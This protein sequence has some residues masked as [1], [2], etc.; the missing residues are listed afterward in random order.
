MP[1]RV[2][3]VDDSKISRKMIIK[4][5]PKD[6]DIEISEACNGKEALD[7][8]HAG[9]AEVMFLDLTM[10]V[11]DGYE[12]LEILKKEGLNTFVIVVSADIQPKARERVISLGAMD[13]IKKPIDTD[14][15]N[16]VLKKFG[17]I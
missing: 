1:T 13:F 6:W 5:L 10:P 9:K 3:V 7:G 2:L 12:A 8:Y 14:K 4:S 16:E 17:I 15:V 11:M